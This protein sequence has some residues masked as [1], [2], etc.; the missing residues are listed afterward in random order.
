MSPTA[1]MPQPDTAVNAPAA[2]HR[3]VLDR[4]QRFA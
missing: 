2:L 3:K 1:T 4:Y